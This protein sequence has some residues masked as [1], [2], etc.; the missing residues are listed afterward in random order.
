MAK[1]PKVFSNSSQEPAAKKIAADAFLLLPSGP[2]PAKSEPNVPDWAIQIVLSELVKR[3]RMA[4]AQSTARDLLFLTK[5][6]LRI[7]NGPIKRPGVSLE[8]LL[9][10]LV[11]QFLRSP[12]RERVHPR[13][14]IQLQATQLLSL[15]KPYK[16]CKSYSA[17]SRWIA[18]HALETLNQIVKIHGCSAT[19]PARTQ[20]PD[21]DT[22][23]DWAYP[24]IAALRDRLLAHYHGVHED[25]I[26]QLWK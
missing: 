8:T 6:A 22:I 24:G 7:E 12:R 23:Q 16:E 3:T 14:I 10:E 15:L 2:T 20:A 9:A 21:S 1:P 18:K 11:R 4:N 5:L 25:R 26:R 17:R 19:C 13:C